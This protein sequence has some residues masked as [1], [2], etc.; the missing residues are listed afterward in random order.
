MTPTQGMVDNCN[1]DN[2]TEDVTFMI[3]KI[4]ETHVVVA[5]LTATVTFAAGFNLPP[6]WLHSQ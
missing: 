6:W 3:E 4:S 1:V 5:T 2:D